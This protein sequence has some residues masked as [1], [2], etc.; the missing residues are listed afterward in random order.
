VVITSERKALCHSFA[1]KF[2]NKSTV[3]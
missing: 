3:K 1:A 2:R